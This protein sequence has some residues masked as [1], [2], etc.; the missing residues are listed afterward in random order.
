MQYKGD[1]DKGQAELPPTTLF[2]PDPRGVGD[3]SGQYLYKEPVG[4]LATD[5]HDTRGAPPARPPHHAHQPH[6]GASRTS[7]GL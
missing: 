7:W 4:R 1:C 6:S 5:R 2:P 3:G